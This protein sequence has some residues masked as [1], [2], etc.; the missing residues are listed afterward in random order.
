MRESQRVVVD[1]L[2]SMFTIPLLPRE[3]DWGTDKC[4]C[5]TKCYHRRKL[6]EDQDPHNLSEPLLWK[7]LEKEQQKGDLDETQN[8]EVRDLTD[9]EV[10]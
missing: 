5:K 4:R 1:T 7:D 2:A 8:G 3:T 10:L 6:E 9:P